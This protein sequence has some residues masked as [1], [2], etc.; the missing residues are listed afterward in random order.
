MIGRMVIILIKLYQVTLG[1]VLGNCC[2]FHPSCSTYAIE[3]IE[4]H[5]WARGLALGLRRL[6]RCHPFHPGGVDP[7]PAR[8]Q[9]PQGLKSV[10]SI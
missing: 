3:A 4:T 7:V 9:A 6:G 8:R 10:G 2:R 1:P 5:G